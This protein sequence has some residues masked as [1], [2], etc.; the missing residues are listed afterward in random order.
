MLHH[1][2]AESAAFCLGDVCIRRLRP[3][4]D[5]CDLG[6][7]TPARGAT[8]RRFDKFSTAGGDGAPFL[9]KEDFGR[10]NSHYKICASACAGAA[11]C[12]S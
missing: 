2:S 4:G 7:G 12:N 10:F 6:G 5:A 11:G 3:S 8:R 1:T 9:T